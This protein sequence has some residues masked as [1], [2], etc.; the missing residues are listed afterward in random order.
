MLQSS[1]AAYL[2]PWIAAGGC[3]KSRHSQAISEFL[4]ASLLTK[5]D[6]RR[7]YVNEFDSG[8]Q[9]LLRR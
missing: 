5:A 8:D 3:D 9:Y 7:R 1:P 6:Q 4:S 2:L